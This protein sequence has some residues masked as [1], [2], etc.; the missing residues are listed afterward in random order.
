MIGPVVHAGPVAFADDMALILRF[1]LPRH[2][3]AE[4]AAGQ[5]DVILAPVHKIHRHI[6]N[7]VGIA[8]EPEPILEHEIQHAAPVRIGVGPDMAAVGH[9]AVRLALLERR[10]GEQR[11]RQRL[12]R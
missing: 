8:L 9:E 3:F 4:R 12:Q 2:V 11:R 6:Q 10:V 1:Q 5:I 7:I